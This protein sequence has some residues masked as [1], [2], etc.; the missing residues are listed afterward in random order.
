MEVGAIFVGRITNYKKDGT[1][2]R[3]GEKGMF[4]FGGS[5]VILLFQKDTITL[6]DAIYENTTRNK[7]T[8]VKMGCSIGEKKIPEVERPQ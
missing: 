4:Q 5:T 1:V 8:V 2:R 3:G 7:E 6:D